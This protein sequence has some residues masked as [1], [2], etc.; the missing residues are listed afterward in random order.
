M[1]HTV[2]RHSRANHTCSDQAWASCVYLLTMFSVLICDQSAS[3]MAFLVLCCK[4]AIIPQSFSVIVF[5][6]GV[7][8]DELHE[9]V[10]ELSSYLVDRTNDSFT[11]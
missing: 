8:L 6:V 11:L 4:F 5:T 10:P 1:C 9:P 7:G 3:F 2:N